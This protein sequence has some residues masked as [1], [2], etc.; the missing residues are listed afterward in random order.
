[1]R[2]LANLAFRLRAVLA[3]GKMER[4]LDDEVTFHLEMETRKLMERG[5]T[6]DE[7]RRQARRSFGSMLRNKERARQAWGIGLVQDLRADARHTFRGF[8]RSPVFA[9]VTVLTLGLGI[10]GTT[11]IFSVVNGVVLKPLP[12]PDPERLVAVHHSMPAVYADE[13]PLSPAMYFTFRDHSRT[14]EDIGVWRRVPV[15]VTGL[16][17]P[18]QVVAVQ[19]T[20]GLFPLLGVNPILGRGYDEEDVAP[21]STNPVILSQGYWMRRFG[22]DPDVLGRTIRI[23]GDELTIIGVMPG[24]LRLGNLAPELYLPLVFNRARLGVGNWSFPGIARLRPGVTPAEASAD[25]N[26]LTV[27]A[28]EEYP[29]IPL[30]D[31]RE[32]QFS[33]F[34]RPLKQDVVGGA[35]RVLWLVFGTAGLVLLVACINVANLFLVRAE[36]RQRDAALR[37][38][39]GAS[40][41]RLTR[42]FITES[43]VIAIVGGSTGLLLA[44][45]GDRLLLHIAPPHLPRLEEI[46]LDSTVL[47]LALG[48][49]VLTGLI[50]GTIPILRYGRAG[51]A[52]SLKEGGRGTSSS[53]RWQ[54]M[55]SL[56]AVSQIAL[57]LVLLI[58]SGLM[59]RTF[60]ALKDVPP[61]FQTPKEV[62]TFRISVPSS[63]AASADD[64]AR[65]HQQILEQIGRIPGVT[66]VGAAASV[67][68]DGW[69]AW[70]DVEVDGFPPTPGEAPVHRRLNWITPG[71]F[72][73][74]ENSLLAGRAIEWEDAY[75]RRP[76]AVVTENFAREFWGR[77]ADA[78]G[79]RFRT[80]AN[81]P[82]REIVGVVQDVHTDGVAEA[83]PSVIYWPLIME[84]MWGVSTFTIRDLRYAVRTSRPDPAALLPEVSDAVW[85]V[86]PNLPLSEIL[87]LDA[88]LAN[89]M[90]RTSFTLVMLGIAAGVALLL[91]IVGVYGVLSYLVTQRTREMGVRLALGA[92]PADVRRMVVRQGAALGAAGVAMGLGAATGLTHLMSALLFGVRPVDSM[93]Y[94]V[95]AAALMG[96]VLLASYVPARRAAGVNP[97]EVLR[98]E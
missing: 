37:S 17:E 23:D 65:V 24:G 6:E 61:G 96:V 68:M 64:A 81:S 29:G 86:N 41:G 31:L 53:R 56:F 27:T 72:A 47:V 98:W 55:R 49:S 14:L 90:A 67:A 20:A 9:A 74:L 8:R 2:W 93:S 87:T 76:V 33:T 82:W 46:G 51:L 48:V 7:A 36:T 57:V 45:A 4:E 13:T 80:A 78:L 43:T 19:V 79:R 97:T 32:R 18:E 35:S 5:M 39:M 60:H 88:I 54:R 63:E 28:T 38:A 66:S 12:F 21:G 58:C 52:E 70:E 73:T 25:L 75:R 26:R 11:A 85:S 62:L 34:V 89:S 59:V 71:Y 22:S 94:G 3:P 95:L 40:S 77:P 30:A 91:G 10:G 83:A 92:R 42:Q 44:L 1:M 50:F 84:G 15:T 69:E 16:A